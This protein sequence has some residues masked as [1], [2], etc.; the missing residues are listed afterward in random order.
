MIAFKL[1]QNANTLKNLAFIICVLFLSFYSLTGQVAV[2]VKAGPNLAHLDFEQSN[3]SLLWHA[4][5]LANFP[6][7]QSLFVQP[8][9]LYN[10][11]G[12]GPKKFNGNSFQYKI[13]YLSMPLLFGYRFRDRFAVIAGPELSTVINTTVYYNQEKSTDQQYGVYE[14]DIALVGGATYKITNQ[15]GLDVRY[16][17]GLVNA[18]DFDFI[19]FYSQTF[20]DLGGTG[21][22]K[23]HVL[24]ASLFYVIR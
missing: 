11:K 20:S 6:I 1:Y 17:Q 14:V 16:S 15:F 3:S 4:G 22:L 2:G 18:V 10:V 7:G 19:N 8:E 21:K 5:I 24:Q 9:I 23:N 13:T 12:S